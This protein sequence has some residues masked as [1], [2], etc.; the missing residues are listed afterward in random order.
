MKKFRKLFFLVTAF[1]MVL[2]LVTPSFA[3]AA[4]TGKPDLK[5]TLDKTNGY[6][7]DE[8][9]ATVH[10]N[11]NS[12]EKITGLQLYLKFDKDVLQ[13]VGD[14]TRV[15][16]KQTDE[17]S[18]LA[19]TEDKVS[20]LWT[21]TSDTGLTLTPSDTG[22]GDKVFTVNFKVKDGAAIGDTDLTFDV[23]EANYPIQDSIANKKI[24]S[25]ITNAK[26]TVKDYTF[27]LNKESGEL[28]VGGTDTLT[29]TF[30]P[31]DKGNGKTV[32]WETSN[33]D[34]VTVDNGTVT[35]KGPGTAKVTARVNSAKYATCTY[36]VKAPLKGITI[37]GGDTITIKKGATKTLSVTYNP[38]N[39]TD[40]K[41]I[42][43]SVE[44]NDGIITLD[45]DTGKVTGLKEG[46]VTITAKSANSESIT[47]TIK[48][49]VEEVHLNSISI[50][51]EDDLTLT[52][53]DKIKLNVLYNPE[54]TTDDKTVTWESSKPEFAS[55]D[56]EGN[57][58]AI[59][60]GKTTI[61]AKVGEKQATKEI[62]VKEYHIESIEL[63]KAEED[64]LTVGSQIPIWVKLNPENC[65]DSLTFKWT[66]SDESIATVDNFGNVKGI[67]EG[68]A[69]ITAIITSINGVENETLDEE[70]NK[71]MAKI[72]V[73]VQPQEVIN[74]TTDNKDG[75][76]PQTGDLPI[77]AIIVVAALALTGSIIVYK[78]KIA[79][80][81]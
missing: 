71:L 64:V 15:M 47:D 48:I 17:F 13:V 43:W 16:D 44:N 60:E 56:Q 63:L 12:V 27:T 21:T 23:S 11:T 20:F 76:S 77:I 81:K 75:K 14:P 59:A 51:N 50:D 78:K 42:K 8:F 61:T 24:E 49:K 37:D 54:D 31:S 4:E 40:D 18:S 32:T 58:T 41:T 38:T 67:K 69:T 1:A 3:T 2:T 57:V 46:E 74:T 65:T 73:E 39:T 68:K 29:T 28:D 25:T 34:V 45:E 6:A 79:T 70:D 33:K 5:V 7:E 62:T 66:S 26:Y 80:Q 55:I 9:T 30:E 53:G 10:L 22:N 19:A 72:D 35:A 36:T 52:K